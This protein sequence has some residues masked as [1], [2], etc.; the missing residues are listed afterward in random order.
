MLAAAQIS[1]MASWVIYVHASLEGRPTGA[2]TGEETPVTRQRR[3]RLQAA[4]KMM[5]HVVKVFV[6]QVGYLFE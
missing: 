6:P 5:S 1:R 3:Q 2:A 4:I